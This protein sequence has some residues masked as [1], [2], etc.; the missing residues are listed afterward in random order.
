[1]TAWVGDTRG[2]RVAAERNLAW[3]PAI[4]TWEIARAAPSRDPRALSTAEASKLIEQFREL[5]PGLLV[6]TGAARP[7]IHLLVGQAAACGLRVA[8]GPVMT[9]SL[10]SA[11]VR[12]LAALGVRR[13]VIGVDGPDAATHERAGGNAAAFATTL[14]A[15][16]AVR[17]AALPLEIVTRLA[18]GTVV[19]LPRTAELVEEF[20]PALWNVS[21]VVPRG[22]GAALG[23]TRASA[24]SA[25]STRG[26]SA[27]GSPSRR[28]RHP[29]TAASWSSATR[30]GGGR[31]WRP[32]P[33][34]VND[35]KGLLFVSHTGDVYPSA[36]LP[37]TT[38]NVRGARLAAVY[39]SSRLFRALR[40]PTRLEGVAA[41]A[42]PRSLR[43]LARSGLRDDREL[44]RP[45]PELPTARLPGMRTAHGPYRQ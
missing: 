6:L 16:A 44:P 35:G 8:L 30:P 45:R 7:D 38:A 27:R 14:A 23:R 17:D 2:N 43:R 20:A 1:M 21:F 9:S 4:A 5:D 3:T 42:L 15:I 31:S 11:A 37:L 18:R 22:E 32:R 19:D 29:P 12:R 24:C 28:P 13:I 10:T 41:R 36:L 40:D 34:P 39:R 26:A 25:S 33:L